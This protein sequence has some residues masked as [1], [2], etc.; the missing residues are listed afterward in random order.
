MRD[1]SIIAVVAT[2]APLSAHQLTRLA[3]RPSLALGRLGAVSNGGSGDIFLAFSTDNKGQIDE[4][5]FGNIKTFPNYQLCTVF[6]AA[7]EATEEAIVNAMVSATTMTGAD[8]LKVEALPHDAV[9]QIF[10]SP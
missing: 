8:G 3:K 10:S 7:V 4:Y 2:D 1:G 6:A 9:R 5:G